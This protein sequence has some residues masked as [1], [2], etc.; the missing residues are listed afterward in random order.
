MKKVIILSGI[1][2][3]GKTHAR[4]HNPDLKDLPYID[5][6]DIYR[7]FAE[8][9]W[10]DATACLIRRVSTLFREH[11][12]VLVEGYFLK[13]SFTR[14]W[15]VHDLKVAGVH[16]ADTREFW[17]PIDLCIHRVSAQFTDG[18]ISAAETR[19]RIELIKK[20]WRPEDV[21]AHGS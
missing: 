19:R 5:I 3:T 10:T 4:T 11:N 14:K 1:S 13:G 17:A 16:N 12:T 20:C 15:L 7:E 18:E 9:D 8:F 6:A 2:G 21:D